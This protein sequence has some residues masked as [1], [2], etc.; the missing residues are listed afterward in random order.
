MRL[1][2]GIAN[3]GQDGGGNFDRRKNAAGFLRIPGQDF[4]RAVHFG[5][6]QPRFGRVNRF[7]R[8][9]R[10][11]LAGVSADV[12]LIAQEEKRRQRAARLD[13]AGRDVLRNLAE[14]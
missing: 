3:V 9:Q 12:G 5:I 14:P 2:P 10:A 6:R 13:L 8:H 11:L 7:G 4:S 1:V